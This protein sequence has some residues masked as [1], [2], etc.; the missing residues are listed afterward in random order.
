MAIIERPSGALVDDETGSFM[1]PDPWMVE[2]GYM[3]LKIIGGEP[4]IRIT[5]SGIEYLRGRLR[6]EGLGVQG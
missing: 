1:L 6:A 3:R 4:V 2:Q 5:E